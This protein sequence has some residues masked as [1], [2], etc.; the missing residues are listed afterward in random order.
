MIVP[1]ANLLLYAYDEESLFHAK[2]KT[3]CAKMSNRP[4]LFYV[5]PGRP[6]I[7]QPT[8]KLRP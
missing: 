7:S 5:P 8:P 2:A 3:W 1:D 4:S 6:G